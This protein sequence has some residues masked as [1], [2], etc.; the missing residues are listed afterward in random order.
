MTNDIMLKK[1]THNFMLENLPDHKLMLEKFN[2]E[3]PKL[4]KQMKIFGKRQSQFMDNFLTVS[5]PTELRNIKQILAEVEA[6][7]GALKEAY[8]NNKKKVIE[9]KKLKRQ[10][11]TESDDIEQELIELEIE[12]TMSEIEDSKLYVSGALRKVNNYIDQFNSILQSLGKKDISEID[13]EEEE[14]KYH[15]MKAFE[16]ALTAARSRQGVIDE[17][18][19]IYFSQLGING[20]QA[21]KEMYKYISSEGAMIAEGFEPSYEMQR[22][23]LEDM[24]KKFKGSSKILIQIKKMLPKSEDSMIKLLD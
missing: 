19:H 18:N 20:A 7:K 2:T 21:Q 23:F 17:G 13:F 8:Y 6:T 5:H 3:M 4:V 24:Y 10:L 11:S 12:K 1:E 16:Q 14:E 9:L 22:K 15:I